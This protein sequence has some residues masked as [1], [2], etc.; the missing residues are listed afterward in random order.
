MILSRRQQFLFLSFI[1]SLVSI[2]MPIHLKLSVVLEGLI[3][4]VMAYLIVNLGL[5]DLLPLE[6]LIFS[7]YP[8]VLGLGTFFA[9]LSLDGELT[10]LNFTTLL[11]FML[12]WLA[13][14]LTLLSSNILN[15][16]TVRT[17]PLRKVA[18]SFTYYLGIV[19]IFV[20]TFSTFR[21]YYHNFWWLVLGIFIMTAFLSGA[22]FYF[23]QVGVLGGEFLTPEFRPKFKIFAQESAILGL[24]STQIIIP[25]I[26]LPVSL[27]IKSIYI[28][29]TVFI[30]VSFFQNLILK[31][32]EK[33]QIYEYLLIW[34]ILFLTVV[35]GK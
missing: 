31:K 3:I 21:L 8:T 18:L 26:F 32:I 19:L 20:W 25:T 13:C 24:L 17:V 23:T 29:G 2:L 1:F 11:I 30:L 7:I 15:V 35:I 33:K 9:I 4:V 34:V 14:Y 28:A 12:F 5:R 10:I 27:L 6:R 22:F 16:A